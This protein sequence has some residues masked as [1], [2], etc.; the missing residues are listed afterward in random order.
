MKKKTRH[1]GAG[2][3]SRD[4]SGGDTNRQKSL[5][6]GQKKSI[7]V[8][9]GHEGKRC[10]YCGCVYIKNHDLNMSTHTILGFLDNGIFGEGWH[11][12]KE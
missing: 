4:C 10:N 5:T 12:Y 3:P 2:C 7:P 9:I 6:E 1:G 11:E 8:S